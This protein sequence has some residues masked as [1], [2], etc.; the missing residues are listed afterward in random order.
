MT[1]LFIKEKY[2]KML[3]DI[4][5]EHCPHA[6]VVAYGSRIQG[7]DNA[8]SGSDL[9]LAIIGLENKFLYGTLKKALQESNIPFFVDIFPLETL[10]QSFQA[11]IERHNIEI[12][13]DFLK[14]CVG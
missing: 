6:R 13:P 8:H 4:F 14:I 1:N 9:D 5:S 3:Q 12:F 2:L 7:G 10:P 11:E